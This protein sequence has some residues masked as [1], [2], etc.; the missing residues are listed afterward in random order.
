MTD[1]LVIGSGGA[2]LSAALKAKEEVNNVLIVSKNYPSH[3]QTC[4]AQGGINAVLKEDAKDNIKNYINDTSKAS[5]KLG[6]I[7]TINLLCTKSKDTITWL[8]SI[9]VPFSRDE[10]SNIAQRKFGGT[11]AKRTCYSSDY[12]GLKI[13]HTLY[14]QCIKQNI[15]F[16][17]EHLLLELIIE[18]NCVKGA[19]FLDILTSQVIKIEA[20]TVI[21]ATGGYAAAYHQFTT[22]SF[23]ST[24][25]GIVKALNIGAKLSNLEFVQFH[26]TSLENKNILISESARGEG[27]YLVDEEGN[28]FIEELKPRDEVA[29]AIFEKNK[30]GQRVFLDLR[31]LG[32]E[33]INT[34][35]PQERN[36]ILN[37]MK[38]KMEDDL[39]PVNPSAHY[40]MG[41]I[42][43]DKDTKTTIQNL[44]ACGECSQS[45][46]HGANR[47]GGNSLL[48]IVTFGLISGENAAKQAKLNKE[49]ENTSSYIFGKVKNDIEK[50]F[51]NEKILDFYKIKKELGKLLFNNAGLFREEKKLKKALDYVKKKKEHLKNIG[52]E[53]KSKIYNRNL[54]ELIELRNIITI[55]ELILISALKRR[56]SRGAHYRI[57]FEKEDEKFDKNTIISLKDGQI[58]ISF[59]DVI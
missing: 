31:H 25:D 37:F 39:I 18:E 9:G 13:L 5:H 29:R 22:N 21:L 35:M 56:E 12:T 27:G 11:K 6:N 26:P 3:S 55:S 17:N 53:D 4:Q 48:E 42:L 20:K 51:T 16:L 50:I 41:G 34:T 57:D 33:K 58:N 38:L 43:T 32:F 7:E 24:G 47:L 2:G 46:I 49:M 36:L 8:D 30:A 10:N 1:V 28:R 52:I 15:D 14:D 40:T 19:I 23:G 45:G 44:Y 59:E 54:V